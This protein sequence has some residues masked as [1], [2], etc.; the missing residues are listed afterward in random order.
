MNYL[1]AQGI[2]AGRVTIVSYGEERPACKEHT[3][4]CWAR[5]RRD[6]FLTKAE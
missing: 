3:E 6:H 5:N 4:A 1:I 2:R